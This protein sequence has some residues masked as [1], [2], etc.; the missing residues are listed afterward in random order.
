[1]RIWFCVLTP[2]NWPIVKNKKLYG[3]PDN[4]L[5]R[6][7]I[8]ETSPEDILIFY[9]KSPIRGIVGVYKVVSHVFKSNSLEP[10]NDR[11]YPF[12]V[13]IEPLNKKTVE[14]DKVIPFRD[15]VGKA[16][17]IKT[18]HSLMGQSIIPISKSEFNEIKKLWMSR[19]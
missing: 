18:L 13:R 19:Q 15:I 17:K 11:L 5:A 1:M 7:R 10:W 2:K 3:V 9:L 4:N 8:Y 16:E 12:R 6:K 14:F